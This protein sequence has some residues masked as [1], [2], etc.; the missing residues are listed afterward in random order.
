[1]NLKKMFFVGLIAALAAFASFTPKANTIPASFADVVT[2]AKAPA[3]VAEFRVISSA[4]AE[5]S[6]LPAPAPSMMP[7]P[8]GSISVPDADIAALLLQLAMNYKTLGVMGIL[9]ILTLLSVQLIKKMVPEDFKYKR[10]VV[11]LVSIAYSILSG[12]VIPG[13]NTASVILSVF[14]SS[15]GAVALFEA[16][17]GAGIIKSA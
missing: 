12:V 3:L 7:A 13:S 1:M 6:P 16:L 11:L 14:I 15:G 9:I 17:K 10:L 5:E 4:F 8:A 2:V